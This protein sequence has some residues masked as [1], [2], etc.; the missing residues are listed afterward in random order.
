[1]LFAM[2]E[3]IIREISCACGSEEHGN[4][5]DV[6]K[7]CDYVVEHT[8]HTKANQQAMM[9]TFRAFSYKDVYGRLNMVASTQITFHIR[10]IFPMLWISQ[11]LKFVW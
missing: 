10:R 6:L 5:D 3:Q 9:E 7:D 8:Y 4:V 11:N 2:W 1:M